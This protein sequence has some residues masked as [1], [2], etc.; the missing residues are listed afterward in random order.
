[1]SCTRGF[2]S[3]CIQIPDEDF[4][5]SSWHLNRGLG[6]R[7]MTPYASWLMRLRVPFLYWIHLQSLNLL[8][9]KS[10]R[11]L[12]PQLCVDPLVVF[13]INLHLINRGNNPA[14]AVYKYLRP[15]FQ[16][17]I[18]HVK[19]DFNFE[20][21]ISQ[22]SYVQCL[23]KILKALENGKLQTWA[24]VFKFHDMLLQFEAASN[25]LRSSSLTTPPRK[26]DF[27]I[28]HQAMQGP[29]QLIR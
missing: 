20:M 7:N 2:C 6:K 28:L 25:A 12:W 13:S 5:C 4:V 1:M 29:L 11:E 22:K 16:G 19:I 10:T 27:C 8:S 24:I 17:N 3:I 18:V 26:M 9:N 15:Y 14:Q 23:N 21:A